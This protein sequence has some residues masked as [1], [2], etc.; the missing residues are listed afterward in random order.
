MIRESCEK[1][2]ALKH[3]EEIELRLY[4]RSRERFDGFVTPSAGEEPRGWRKLKAAANTANERRANTYKER[5]DHEATCPTC[6]H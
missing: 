5:I 1:G 2:M 6:N 4:V 3:Q